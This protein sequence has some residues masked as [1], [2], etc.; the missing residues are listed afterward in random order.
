MIYKMLLMPINVQVGK[1]C[2][3]PF[4]SIFECEERK[5]GDTYQLD[6]NPMTD[7]TKRHLGM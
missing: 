3:V 4:A 1:I 6:C 5:I 2:N 7:I